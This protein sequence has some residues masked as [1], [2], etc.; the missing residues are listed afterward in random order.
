[1]PPQGAGEGAGEGRLPGDGPL[2]Y[3]ENEMNHDDAI[4]SNAVARYLLGEM[5]EAELERYEAHFFACRVCAREIAVGRE[6]I[7][8]LRA[9]LAAPATSRSHKLQRCRVLVRSYTSRIN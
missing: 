9:A 5:D 2:P 6:L 3:A 4:R 7:E 8:S 1:V